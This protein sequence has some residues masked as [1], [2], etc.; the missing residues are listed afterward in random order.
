MLLHILII[1]PTAITITAARDMRQLVRIQPA[2]Q[3][4]ERQV[5][6]VSMQY[7]RCVLRPA[8]DTIAAATAASNAANLLQPPNCQILQPATTRRG[9]E[10]SRGIGGKCVWAML[11]W[12]N[13]RRHLSRL[14]HWRFNAVCRLASVR[15]CGQTAVYSCGSDSAR[16]L[17]WIVQYGM[18]LQQ[19]GGV[20]E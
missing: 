11:R 17:D 13:R 16:E 9:G 4:V 10:L 6:V 14:Q 7:L 8:A 20:D 5:H 19:R 18:Q 2:H 1:A 12:F 3:S 15:V